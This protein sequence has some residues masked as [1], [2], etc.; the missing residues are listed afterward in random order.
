[1]IAPKILLAAGGTGG[2][3]FPAVAV[4]EQL[5]AAG[6]QPVFITDKRGKAMI[7]SDYRKTSIFA[8]SPYGDNLMMRLKGLLKLGLGTAQTAF[9]LILSRPKVVVGFGGY[10]AVA[11]VIV[12]HVMGKPT[13]LH[14]QNAFLGRANHF[15]AHY[16]KKIGLSWPET[17]NVPAAMSH[18]I[19]ITGM[20]VRDAFD[21][22]PGYTPPKDNGP[23]R[24]LI[25]GGSLGAAIFGETVPDA[26]SR[27]PQALRERLVVTHQVRQEQIERVDEKY[28]AAG[29]KVE[30]S[31]FIHDMAAAMADAHLV[32]GRAGAS[33]V[34]ELATAGRPAL[35]VPYPHAMDDHQTANAE[36]VVAAKGGWLIP[37]QEMSA[38][39]LA[40]KIAT[41]ISSPD[42]LAQAASHICNLNKGNAAKIIADHVIALATGQIDAKNAAKNTAKN[43]SG[44]PS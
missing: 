7:P 37:E 39:S 13:M 24:M 4:A 31:P 28:K 40:G 12:G 15:L 17:R 1:M 21:Q 26:I 33:S 35:L 23:I 11:P 3:V 30:L 27:L 36:A 44:E 14:E 34:A 19:T 42:Q 32:I 22:M 8:A 9:V 18:K 25:V 5:R 38:G 6:Y 41:L 43:A 10:P 2:H 20:P 16:S 29:I